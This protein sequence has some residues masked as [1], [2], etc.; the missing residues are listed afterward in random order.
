MVNLAAPGWRPEKDKIA[1][2]LK[3]LSEAK[4]GPNDTVIL[5]LLSN[6]TYMGSDE[7]GMPTPPCK[8]DGRYHVLSNL[9]IAPGTVLNKIL[10]DCRPLIGES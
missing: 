3:S 2:T 9:Q 1:K 5:D 6:S 10:C 4:I 7:S 8:E